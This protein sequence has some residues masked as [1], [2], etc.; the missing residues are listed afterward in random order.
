[1][2]GKLKVASGGEMIVPSVHDA[3]LL[4]V[5]LAD[6]SA[7]YIPMRL[8]DGASVCIV[9]RGVVRLRADDFR[10]GNVV[11][12]ITVSGAGVR[13]CDLQ[14]VY[15]VDQAGKSELGFLVTVEEDFSRGKL[16]LV[17]INASYGCSLSC[18]CEEIDVIEDCSILGAYE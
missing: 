9:L 7:L 4:G 12:D 11:L 2:T 13:A 14:Y 3:N 1:M 17:E 8:I 18:V 6:P 5:V 16:K 15:G 10:Q